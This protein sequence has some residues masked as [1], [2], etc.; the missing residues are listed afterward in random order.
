MGRR[1]DRTRGERTRASRIAKP[2]SG[3]TNL[4]VAGPKTRDWERAPSGHR[5]DRHCRRW[6]EE[7]SAL[8]TNHCR[9]L[10]VSRFSDSADEDA[11]GV[12]ALQHK[13]T[14]R[15]ASV[16]GRAAVP[17]GGF[18]GG[19]SRT[20]PR[21]CS[22]RLTPFPEKSGRFDRLILSQFFAS[23]LLKPSAARKRESAT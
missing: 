3:Q 16:Y 4:A 14:R 21:A 23:L 1:L 11:G 5:S 2:V 18:V 17:G 7:A 13:P 19:A 10:V 20:M 6:R 12:S 8:I 15:A 22:A 9:A